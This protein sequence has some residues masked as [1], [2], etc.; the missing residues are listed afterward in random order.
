MANKGTLTETI[1]TGYELKIVWNID[2]QSIPNNTS[3][4]MVK[5]QLVS[6]GSSYAINST[7][8]KSGTLYIDG[9]A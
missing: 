8:P 4:V 6:T 7:A 9:K 5:V 1:R 2:S 3:N